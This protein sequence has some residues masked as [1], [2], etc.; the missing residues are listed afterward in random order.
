MALA[1]KNLITAIN[2]KLTADSTL[3]ALITGVFNFVPQKQTYPYVVI[4]DSD[5]FETKFNTFARK[6]KEI[7]IF[8]HVYSLYK[9]D[10]EALE[11]ADAI[12]SLLDW[13]SLTI[14]FNDHILTAFEGLQLEVEEEDSKQY[15]ARHAILEYRIITQ[16]IYSEPVNS[17][18]YCGTFYAGEDI[19]MITIGQDL[20]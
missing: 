15:K 16:E 10:S 13:Q 14:T 17:I 6:G 1:G 18:K 9:G 7:R 12:D 2:S 19:E 3:M 4:N 8:I 5:F 11:I 20:T